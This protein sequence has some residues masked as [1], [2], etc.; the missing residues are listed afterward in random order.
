MKQKTKR[1]RKITAW[2]ERVKKYKS[3][4]GV[5]YKQALVALKGNKQ[6]I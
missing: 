6:T 2:I 3:E 4:N 5:S 1:P